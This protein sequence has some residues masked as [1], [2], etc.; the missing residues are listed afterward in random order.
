VEAVRVQPQTHSQSVEPPDW[1]VEVLKHILQHA[2]LIREFTPF[3][4]H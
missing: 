3:L 4:G 2:H 1:L